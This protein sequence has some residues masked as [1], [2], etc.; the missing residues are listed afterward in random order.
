M[1]QKVCQMEGCR[2]LTEQS[3]EI[4]PAGMTPPA[5]N[6]FWLCDKHMKEVLERS[7]G[8]R[9]SSLRVGA[10]WSSGSLRVS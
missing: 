5:D 3:L 1:V 7:K 2:E 10:G 4:A 9:C 8:S 6:T